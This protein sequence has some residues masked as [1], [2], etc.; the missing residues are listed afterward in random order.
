MSLAYEAASAIAE[1]KEIEDGAAAAAFNKV[2]EDFSEPSGGADFGIPMPDLS[3]ILAK[4][5]PGDIDDYLKHPLNRSGSR[6]IAQ[7]LRGV[8]GILGETDFAIVDMAL[9]ALEFTKEKKQ[10]VSLEG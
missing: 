4:T 1:E 8:T 6:G 7:I 2:E 10:N 9:G 5:G 3:I